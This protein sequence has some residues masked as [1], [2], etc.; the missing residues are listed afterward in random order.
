MFKG[1]SRVFSST[2]VRKHSSLMHQHSAFFMVQLSHPCMTSREI[3]ALTMTIWAF[4]GKVM[5]LFF[6]TLFRFVIAVLPRS[7][8]LSI[9]W[10]QS[11]STAQPF[12][13]RMAS[14]CCCCLVTQS[15][16]TLWNLMDCSTPG[17]PVLHSL[18]EFDQTHVH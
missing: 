11:L 6:N 15:C 2:T 13:V 5:T 18:P 16:L 14:S 9:S 10:F 4:V 17:F 3:R 1:L 12:L 7:K 8:C